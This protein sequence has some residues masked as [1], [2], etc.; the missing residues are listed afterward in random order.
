MSDRG[1][2]AVITSYTNVI[3]DHVVVPRCSGE[4]RRAKYKSE[5]LLEKLIHMIYMGKFS[6]ALHDPDSGTAM[7]GSDSRRV[8]VVGGR[9]TRVNERC[10]SLGLDV[11]SSPYTQHVGVGG[12][13]LSGGRPL[14]VPCY[15]VH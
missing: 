6:Q 4:N 14:K 10:A 1:F 12:F 7:I 2:P 5:V 3:S 15:L 13:L 8:T 11:V 9:V